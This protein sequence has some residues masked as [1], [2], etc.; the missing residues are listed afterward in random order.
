MFDAAQK[1]MDPSTLDD[2]P[3]DKQAEALQL[4]AIEA[5]TKAPPCAPAPV[6]KAIS[7]VVAERRRQIDAEGWTVEHDDQHTDYSI[8][9]AAAVYALMASEACKANRAVMDGFKRA[10]SVPAEI[11]SLWPLAWRMDW[12]KPHSRRNDLVRAGALILAEIERL[13]RLSEVERANA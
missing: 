10:S 4:M 7:D 12:L 3:E 8:S 13:D 11:S 1:I 2:V 9:R 5:L 6:S